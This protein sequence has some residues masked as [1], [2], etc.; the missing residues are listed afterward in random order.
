MKN[1]VSKILLIWI[2]FLMTACNGKIS[3]SN[4]ALT[5]VRLPLGFIPNVQF[6]PL[7]VALEKGY[8]RDQGLDVTL[9]YNMEN[10]NIAL[11]GANQYQFAVA[12]GEQ[13]LLGRDKTLPVVYVM[14]WYHRFPVGVVSKIEQGI[15]TPQDLRGKTIGI[16][17][18]FGA[19]Y[20]GFR[21]LLDQNGIREDELT[22]DSI[23]FTQAEAVD[24]DRVDAA[25]IYIPNEP[26]VLRARGYQ[27]NVL[28][29][30]DYAPLIANGLITNEK[31]IADHPAL[32]KAMVNAFQ[33]AISYSIAHPEEAFD[34]SK[35]YVENLASADQAL[36][37]QVLL[38]SIEL[39]INPTP[40][41]TD[42]AVWQGMYSLLSKF[43]Y[44]SPQLDIS[45]AFSNEF[46][47]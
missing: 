14:E 18:L 25:V 39:W 31:T 46:L 47:P 30:S 40:G 17:G 28:A 43:G 34:I 4:T 45:Q 10:D 41:F 32:V 5:Q 22:L 13:V 11:L 35:K 15:T 19:S 7:Y 24:Q 37:M 23:G 6:A 29:V 36:Q 1:F 38:T 16:P 2:I 20:I 33:N 12:S 3:A 9:D 8:F 44:I 27:V 21:A 26:N 42:P